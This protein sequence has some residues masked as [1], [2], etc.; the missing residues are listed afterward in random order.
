MRTRNA[1][2][3]RKRVGTRAK[4]IR[5]KAKLLD[6]FLDCKLGYF[7]VK[8]RK[9]KRG[10][11][12]VFCSFRPNGYSHFGQLMFEEE[13]E[14]LKKGHKVIRSLVDEFFEEP[15][16]AF[17]SRGC[18]VTKVK[19]LVGPVSHKLLLKTQTSL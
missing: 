13:V 1:P 2:S 6:C 19:N 7:P 14:M 17:N 11:N 18:D 9:T 8:I 12:E 3:R 15:M 4:I 5:D 16:T 10:F